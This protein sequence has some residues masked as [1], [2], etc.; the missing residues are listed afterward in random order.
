MDTVLTVPTVKCANS[1]SHFR[2]TVVRIQR[3]S[4]RLVVEQRSGSQK[5]ISETLV[6]MSGSVCREFD[7]QTRDI[8]S[9]DY[10]KEAVLQLSL[11]YTG[12]LAIKGEIDDTY[13]D[14][15]LIFS[16]AI[17]AL[18]ISEGEVM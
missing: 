8:Y 15:E 10:W 12:S 13:R 4:L 5:R 6:E 11:L 1:K 9:V 17:T 2:K 14:N 16:T 3:S 7:R 18:K